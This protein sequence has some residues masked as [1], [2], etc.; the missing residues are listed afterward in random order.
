MLVPGPLRESDA[1]DGLKDET[2]G[3]RQ[4]RFGRLRK[5]AEFLRVAAGGKVANGL[6]SLQ[7]ARRPQ[8]GG[9][10]VA[11]T[12][13]RFGFTV[14][15]KIGGAVERNR[16][17]RRLKEAVRLAP[18]LA[19]KPGHDYVIVARRAALVAPLSALIEELGRATRRIDDEPALTGRRRGSA[20]GKGQALKA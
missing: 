3:H 17:R 2:A 10:P 15:K 13:I 18:E 8:G 14:T 19:T 6:F 12:E 11:P 16:I 9:E 4:A 5:R 20:R 7:A 1:P